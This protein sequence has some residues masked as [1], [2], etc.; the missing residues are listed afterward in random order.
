VQYYP[1]E[2]NFQLYVNSRVLKMT[3]SNAWHYVVASFDGVNAKL[4]VDGG[5]PVTGT[6]TLTW[7]ALVTS[8]GDR[9]T[10]GRTFSGRLDEIR[11]SNVARSDAYVLTSYNNQNNANTFYSVGVEES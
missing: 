6:A 9:S 11:L 10:G 4:S 7:P 1:V 2:G 8:L 3:A 5:T